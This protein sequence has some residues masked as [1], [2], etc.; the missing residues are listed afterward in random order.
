[1]PKLNS[2]AV[3]FAYHDIRTNELT[4]V[5]KDHSMIKYKDVPRPVY[6]ELLDSASHGDYYNRFI[7]SEYKF[8]YL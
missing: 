3:K 7:R 8:E 5:L 1:M 6:H 2:S 4:V